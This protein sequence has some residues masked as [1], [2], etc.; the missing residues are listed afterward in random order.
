MEKNTSLPAAVLSKLQPFSNLFEIIGVAI[1]FTYL[2]ACHLQFFSWDWMLVAVIAVFLSMMTEEDARHQTVDVFFLAVLAVMMFLVSTFRGNQD[3]FVKDLI[4]GTCFFRFLLVL[5][6]LWTTCYY[7][8]VYIEDYLQDAEM[9]DEVA[10][11]HLMG[12]LPIF[13]IVFVFWLGLGD[14]FVPFVF[15]QSAFVFDVLKE[16]ADFY[17]LFPW[18]SVAIWFFLEAILWW[19]EHKR[20]R[21]ILWGFGGGDVLFLGIFSGYLGLAPLFALFFVSLFARVIFFFLHFFS[22]NKI[23]SS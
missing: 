9:S 16:I 1:L 5:I 6:S 8:P 18:F 4:I 21:L 20:K 19:M 12:Y 13:M 15:A 17:V 7:P 22:R 10:E 23:A 2:M 11:T 3:V 14:S